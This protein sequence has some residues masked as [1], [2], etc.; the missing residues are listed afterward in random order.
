M[1]IE[2]A[3]VPWYLKCL[4]YHGKKPRLSKIKGWKCT[5]TYF[6]ILNV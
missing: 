6:N 4:K 2:L 1:N 3:H 5:P